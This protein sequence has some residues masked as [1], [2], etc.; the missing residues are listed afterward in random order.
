MVFKFF[1]TSR[2]LPSFVMKLRNF[3]NKKKKAN[4]ISILK[5][6]S[7]VSDFGVVISIGLAVLIDIYY[8]FE[9]PKLIVPLKF[10]VF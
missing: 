5:I 1:R 4:C 2:F 9:T 7:K 10:E 8:G 6:R 3:S